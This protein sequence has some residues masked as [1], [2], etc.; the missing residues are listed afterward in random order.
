MN[1]VNQVNQVNQ[2]SQV[3]ELSWI[4]SMKALFCAY[5]ANGAIC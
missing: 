2:V 3:K 4:W 1:W 5:A